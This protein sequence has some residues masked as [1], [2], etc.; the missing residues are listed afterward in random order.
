[1]RSEKE[2]LDHL[3]SL[4]ERPTSSRDRND[5]TVIRWVMN[6]P[7]RKEKTVGDYWTEQVNAGKA[8]HCHNCG[9]PVGYHAP[10]NKNDLH[11]QAQDEIG[12]CM[13]KGLKLE[14]CK[15]EDK[16]W[17][18]RCRYKLENENAKRS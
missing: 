17:C 18:W 1:M 5:A 10:S 11:C 15:V 13:C 8:N 2:I 3:E 4:E 16:F 12:V 7:P 14:P 6:L 9:C